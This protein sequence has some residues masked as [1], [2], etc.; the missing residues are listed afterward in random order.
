MSYPGW[1]Q[2]DIFDGYQAI[3]GFY[4]TPQIQFWQFFGQALGFS[5]NMEQRASRYGWNKSRL[6]I[7]DQR[8]INPQNCNLLHQHH[9][10]AIK[11][12]PA[13]AASTLGWRLAKLQD[14]SFLY[15]ILHYRPFSTEGELVLV[16][17]LVLW[18][19][20]SS[21]QP[22]VY[23]R[24]SL[25]PQDAPCWVLHWE[26]EDSLSSTSEV[27]MPPN[28]DLGTQIQCCSFQWQCSRA[29]ARTSQLMAVANVFNVYL[30]VGTILSF[31]SWDKRAAYA[32]SSNDIKVK[33][34]H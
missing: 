30:K 1:Y 23:K 33:T 10:L 31:T 13:Y 7:G 16:D 5:D 26:E 22:M 34:L 17:W 20:F 12:V 9:M 24:Q 2:H 25:L 6:S 14:V 32:N 29:H 3:Q 28:Y 11:N 8:I 19:N 21:T 18:W 27:T 4:Y 15:E